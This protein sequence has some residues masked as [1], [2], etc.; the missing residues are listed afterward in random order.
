[1]SGKY[2]NFAFDDPAFYTPE[3]VKQS[4]NPGHNYTTAEYRKEYQRLYKVAQKR[5]RSFENAGRTDA[6]AYR[7]NI[8]R[9]KPSTQL[10]DAQ[11]GRA[12]NDV[13][14]MLTS[15]RGSVTGLRRWE[16]E[17]VERF[18][19]MGLDFINK[20]NLREFGAFMEEAR[21]QNLDKIY[22]SEQVVRLF[23]EAVRKKIDP[24]SI[25]ADFRFFME[26]REVLSTLPKH[27]SAE[28]RTAEAYRA[29]IEK[30][31]KRKRGR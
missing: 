22:G 31:S 6:A 19:E 27:K 29:E 7:Y 26:N 20:G 13:Y 25:A 14:R 3:A 5:L 28:A 11:L 1:M 21:T 9:L 16:T 30:T 8:D 18:H 2:K 17:Q 24:E 12:L 10:T 4:R 23:G 15:V